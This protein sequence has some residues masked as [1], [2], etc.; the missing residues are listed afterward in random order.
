MPEIIDAKGLACPQ[1]VILTKKALDACEEVTILVDN[2]AARDNIKRMAA[3]SGCAVDV[4]EEPGPVFRIYIK[5]QQPVN[6]GDCQ[7]MTEAIIAG[8]EPGTITGQTVFV[9]SSDVM[10]EGNDELGTI[11]MRA[12]IHTVGELDCPPAV[13]IFYNT[14]VR[15]TASDSAVIDDLKALEG[16][17]VELMIC[18]TCVNYFKLGGRLGAGKIS[19]MYDIT[20]VLS[21]AGRIVKP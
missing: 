5:K 3:K 14:G 8:K 4:K 21:A 18:G 15:L 1:P 7:V 20:D 16:K 13:M 10:G 17:G 12:F 9:I 2:N 11:L 19:N 6:S